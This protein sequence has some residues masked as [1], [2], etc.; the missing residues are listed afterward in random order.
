M[1]QTPDLIAIDRRTYNVLTWVFVAIGCLGLFAGILIGQQFIGTVAYLVAVWIGMLVAFGVPYINRVKL[2]DERDWNL[3][4][5]VSGLTLGIACIV[6]VSVVPALYVL[7]AGGYFIITP[8][9]WGAIY[10][11][12]ALALVY[13]VCYTLVPFWN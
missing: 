9:L 13:G 10:V 11:A 12:S 4:N 7:N 3:H 6:T 8:T 2:H 1:N 5:R